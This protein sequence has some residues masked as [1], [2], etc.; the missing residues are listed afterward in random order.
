MRVWLKPIVGVHYDC[1]NVSPY[2]ALLNRALAAA[3]RQPTSNY[4]VSLYYEK[5]LSNKINYWF[6]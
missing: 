4:K 3:E 1:R 5:L 2:C 6:L